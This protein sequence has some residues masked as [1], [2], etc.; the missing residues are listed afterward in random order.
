M[1]NT[2]YI[3]E[4]WEREGSFVIENDEWSEIC[5]FQWKCTNSHTWR[6]FGWKCLIRFFITPKQKAHFS[7]GEATC[8][9]QCGSREANHWH[10]FWDC[11]VIKNFWA[12]FHRSINTIF[13]T[14]LQLEFAILF[15]GHPNLQKR[16]DEYLFG[17]LISACRKVLTRH[18]LL[19]EA[20]TINE[21]IDLVN[22]IYVME[23]ITFSLRLQKEKFIKYW[24][25]WVK[26]VVP[27]RPAFIRAMLE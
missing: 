16:S 11:P 1:Y 14:N 10:I 3:K 23:Q 4:K 17:V 6:E 9:R 21:W 8:W 25:N 12:E 2:E 27:L 7:E 24:A 5:E 18:W 15:L 19:P 26:Y 13:N 20:P 22:D